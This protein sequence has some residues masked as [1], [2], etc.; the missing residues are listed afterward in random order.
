MCIP[1]PYPVRMRPADDFFRIDCVPSILCLCRVLLRC[2]CLALIA[3]YS[4]NRA[5]WANLS[6]LR[7]TEVL[8]IIGI[9]DK[10]RHIR[11]PPSLHR[12]PLPF[13]HLLQLVNDV[14]CP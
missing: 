2:P 9:N 7:Q 5:S 14:A 13:L 6:L 10:V 8:D 1:W 12:H 4:S 3:C 11:P